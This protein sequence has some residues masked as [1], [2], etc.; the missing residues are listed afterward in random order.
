LDKY[1]KLGKPNIKGISWWD[2]ND[3]YSFITDGGLLDEN[4]KPKKSYEALKKLII[5]IR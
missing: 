5:N 2:A 4:N 1:S 3:R